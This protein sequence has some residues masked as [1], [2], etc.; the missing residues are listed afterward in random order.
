MNKRFDGKT[1]VITGAA[2]GIGFATARLLLAEGA[3][4]F[5]VDYDGKTL[6]SSVE[7]LSSLGKVSFQKADVSIEADV[8]KYV[9]CAIREFGS[10]DVFHN[11]AGIMG[12]ISPIVDTDAKDFSRV[13]DVNAKGIFLGLK[14]VLQIMYNQGYGTVV[15]TASVDSF[16]ADDGLS[17]Y[18][19][20]KHAVMGIT[21]TAALEAAQHGVRVNAINPGLVD[22]PMQHSYEVIE[23]ISSK[24]LTQN[25]PLQRY[26]SPTE[27]AQLVAFLLSDESSYI[28]GSAHVVD[29]GLYL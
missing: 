12:T 9:S 16:H 26:S 25:I 29:G 14:H 21:R 24:S 18:V 3:N 19:A 5:L 1:A 10:I 15:N 27:I 6:E 28:T 2:S 11:N 13:L 22:T 7:S 17:P 23:G 20:S 4:V 8:E